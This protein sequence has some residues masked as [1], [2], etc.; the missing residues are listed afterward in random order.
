MLFGDTAPD[1]LPS[2]ATA[3]LLLF[4]VGAPGVP[5][6]YFEEALHCCAEALDEA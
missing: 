5:A 3:R 6:L 1:R 4:A 2:R